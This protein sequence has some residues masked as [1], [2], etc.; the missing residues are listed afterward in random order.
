MATD[1]GAQQAFMSPYMQNVV[2]VQRQEAIRG[3]QQGQLA[4]NLAAARTGTY[5][6]AR[7]T[8]SSQHVR[9]EA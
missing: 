3:A 2:D 1:P 4:Q 6:G 9:S 5:G 8:P 7:Q